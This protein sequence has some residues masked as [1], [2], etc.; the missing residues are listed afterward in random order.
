MSL[1]LS[2]FLSFLSLKN[3]DPQTLSAAGTHNNKWKRCPQASL[4]KFSPPKPGPIFPHLLFS[5]LSV[6]PHYQD[7]GP[8]RVKEGLDPSKFQPFLS[9]PSGTVVGH[10]Q[11]YSCSISF[12][13]KKYGKKISGKW[14][15]RRKVTKGYF[16]FFANVNHKKTNLDTF[17]NLCHD[18][19]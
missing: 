2:N 10:A 11:N 9:P 19:T 3:A 5:L 6:W 16:G 14:K 12:G 18:I 13:R 4:H 7:V 17:I 8:W 15:M 1:P